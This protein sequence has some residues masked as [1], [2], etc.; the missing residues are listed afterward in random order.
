MLAGE[1]GEKTEAFASQRAFVCIRQ[2]FQH[3]QDLTI[4]V[5][6]KFPAHLA[7]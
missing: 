2:V 1:A 4:I 6:M 5:C 7:L 3:D